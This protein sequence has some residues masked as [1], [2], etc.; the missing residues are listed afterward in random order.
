MTSNYSKMYMVTPAIY[1][2]VKS[3][4]TDIMQRRTLE[5]H[6]P[7][8]ISVAELSSQD[9]NLSATQDSDETLDLSETDRAAIPSTSRGIRAAWG[10]PVA[11]ADQSESQSQ[12]QQPSQSTTSEF[13]TQDASSELTRQSPSRKSVTFGPTTFSTP[14]EPDSTPKR[15][16]LKCMLC[17]AEYVNQKSLDN[18]YITIHRIPRNLASSVNESTLSSSAIRSPI[19]TQTRPNIPISPLSHPSPTANI[20]STVSRTPSTSP[21]IP[22]SGPPTTRPLSFTPTRFQRTISP[23]SARSRQQTTPQS[24]R[25]L[26]FNETTVT[27]QRLAM[28]P[29]SPQRLN[30]PP[31]SPRRQPPPIADDDDA[32]ENMDD[33]EIRIPTLP[34]KTCQAQ[35][36][37]AQTRSKTGA[38]PAVPKR[39]PLKKFVCDVC[40]KKFANRFNMNRHI[41]SAHRLFKASD[42]K[43]RR[44]HDITRN[45]KKLE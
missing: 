8:S 22:R 38:R 27:P 13:T 44:Q 19:R 39:S 37:P 29:P 24:A 26:N 5:H 43:T 11:D 20:S 14:L 17:P 35:T 45:W 34:L 7:G 23:S 40:N 15:L 1:N 9:L 3:N 10:D 36:S 42:I 6:N 18:H 12:T 31:P 28:P 25:Q 32:E 41:T 2:Q 30:M 33:D 4:L 16:T 21:E